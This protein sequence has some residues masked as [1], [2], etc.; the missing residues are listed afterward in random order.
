MMN[1]RVLA[2]LA[3]VPV[4]CLAQDRGTITGIVTDS[5]GSSIPGT[6]V[7]FVHPATGLTQ[8]TSTGP[9]GSYTF[10]NLTSGL[11][12]L[13]AAAEGFR[14][15]QVSD[16][17]VQVNTTTRMDIQLE[18]GALQEVVEVVGEAP[19]LQ[20]DRSDLGRVV[21]NRAIQKLPLFL[22][23]GLRSNNAFAGLVPGVAMNLASDPDTTAI[24][25]SEATPTNQP[26]V[27]DAG[28]SQTVAVGTPVTLDATEAMLTM[29]HLSGPASSITGI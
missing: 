5:S 12:T 18:V 29:A 26:P 22:S 19:L 25:V 3:L 1:F 28:P 13:K 21:D 8:T 15:T 2:L 7:S 4:L 20:A 9:D 17:Q 16:L 24:V 27:A 23:G 10:V 6:D 11:Y 14:T